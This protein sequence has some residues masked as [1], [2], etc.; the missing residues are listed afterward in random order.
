MESPLPRGR[1]LRPIT[2][3]AVSALMTGFVASLLFTSEACSQ[4]PAP[5]SNRSVPATRVEPG[6]VVSTTPPQGWSHLVIKSKP[7]VTAGDIASVGKSTC[8]MAGLLFTTITAD[9]ETIQSPDGPRYQIGRVGVGC[10]TEINGK[11]VIITSD[12]QAQ[13]GANFGLIERQVLSAFDE[14]LAE[15]VVTLRT[16]QMVFLDTPVV[17]RHQGKNKAM[18]IR[19]AIIVDA[20]TGRLDTIAWLVDLDDSRRMTGVVGRAQWLANGKQE[21]A[22]L[23]V[24]EDEFFFG[25][26]SDKAFA[27]TRIPHGQLQF[28]MPPEAAAILGKSTLSAQEAKISEQWLHTVA[29]FLRNYQP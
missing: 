7:R 25:I 5:V 28:T 3:A 23:H 22:T 27:I 17:A 11:D 16:P 10:G 24:D 1:S 18:M 9:V 4:N 21:D 13:L 6:A 20:T 14:K 15:N 26:P 2:T 29:D 12:T 19:Y 8:D